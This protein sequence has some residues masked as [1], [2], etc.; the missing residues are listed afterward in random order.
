ME[1][2]KA[3]RYGILQWDS[4]SN[5]SNNTFLKPLFMGGFLFFVTSI[6]NSYHRLLL[7][8]VYRFVFMASVVERSETPMKIGALL[9]SNNSIPQ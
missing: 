2:L 8:S 1:Y 4:T 9:Y 3:N 5:K 7:R 6:S